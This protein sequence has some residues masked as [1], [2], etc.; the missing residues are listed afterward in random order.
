MA[1]VIRRC[2]EQDLDELLEVINDAAPA[3]RGV[4]PDAT[5]QRRLWSSGYR[6]SGETDLP[7]SSHRLQRH[8]SDTHR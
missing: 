8:C 5:S 1:E 4:I 3:Y 6:T 2:T 7:F